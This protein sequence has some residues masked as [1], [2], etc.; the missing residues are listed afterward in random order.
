MSNP[1]S[2]L[3]KINELNPYDLNCNIFT[4][5][6]FDSGSIQE[7]LCKFFEK[8]NEC[9]K[10]SNATFKLA[11]WLVS[12][13]LKQEVALTLDKWLSDGTIQ[14]LINE[15]IFK[16]LNDKLNTNILNTE[17]NKNDITELKRRLNNIVTVD[18]SDYPTLQLAHDKVVE[19]GGG[20]LNI[21]K[22]I[23]QTTTF[24]WDV[25][26][27]IINGNGHTIEFN[28]P[29]KVDYAIKTISSESG[30]HPYN[31]CVNEIKN[32]KIKGNKC[33]G[34]LFQG[35][36]DAKACSHI[37]L[38]RC[39]LSNFNTAL[40]FGNNAYM[41]TFYG[42][43]MFDN[44][45]IFNMEESVVNTGENI[46]FV[47]C[48]LYNSNALLKNKTG[49]NDIF[50]TNCSIDY[51]GV[52]SIVE[53]V[54]RVFFSN[55]HLENSLHNF[56]SGVVP[57][58]CKGD[59]GL[60]SI[61][62][63]F[64]LF[65]GSHESLTPNIFYTEKLQCKISITNSWFFGA[66][67]TSGWLCG[68]TGNLVMKNNQM[69]I[70]PENNL[71]ISPATSQS[72]EGTMLV[73]SFTN[74][75]LTNDTSPITE[76]KQNGSN[77][78]ISYSSEQ[79]VKYGKSIKINKV[80]GGGSQAGFIITF[81]IDRDSINNCEVVVKKTNGNGN[82]YFGFGY[83][84]INGV[85]LNKKELGVETKNYSDVESGWDKISKYMG[86]SPSW[87]T[88]GYVLV[89]MDSVSPMNMYIGEISA[90]SF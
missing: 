26:K 79:S 36:T 53:T 90:N 42:C 19:L 71:R 49:N 34:I 40:E 4:V 72:P 82:C 5:Y 74:I 22:D 31:Q 51:F 15:K 37:G 78:S 68:G 70:V 7:L 41:V 65:D 86:Q 9:I 39:Q 64:I 8:I 77:I 54:G 57:Y 47:S 62:N 56:N 6:D 84:S 35:E 11:E 58:V 3:T 13:G 52:G 23:S 59:A 83:C 61:D 66:K 1:I 18:V 85:N 55:C 28:L 76:V 75:W 2:E 46:N 29:N 38:H 12:V 81:P 10:V 14:S 43:D 25:R 33:N 80:G 44:E 88:H 21:S 27:V 69:N 73:D 30:T 63:S 17:T 89:N 87:A 16:E 60:I 45:T 32:L 48:C 20:V 24:N 50:F 67:T